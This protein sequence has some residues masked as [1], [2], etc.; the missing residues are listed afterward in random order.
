[1]TTTE[2]EGLPTNS[3]WVPFPKPLGHKCYGSIGHLPGSK[4]GPGDHKIQDG[5]A[6]ILTTKKRDKHDRII[7]QEKYDGSGVGVAK[8]YGKLVPLLRAGHRATNSK[9]LQHLYFHNWVM[10]RQEKFDWLQEGQRI[11]GEW[12]AQVHSTAYDLDDDIVFVAFDIM[13]G[14]KRWPYDLFRKITSKHGITRARLIHEGDPISIEEAA[15]KLFTLW[16]IAIDKP[17]GLVY[18]VENKDKVDFLGKW[19]RPDFENKCEENFK[20]I[21]WNWQPRNKND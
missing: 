2:T 1:M 3:T 6:R 16:D 14:E 8:I 17:E 12:L 15:H 4:L 11:C 19:V 18:R 10:E 5:Q 13:E 21:K 7:V 9:Q 20:N